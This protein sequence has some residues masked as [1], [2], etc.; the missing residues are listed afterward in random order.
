[1]PVP[2][3]EWPD[4]T[5][6][7][8]DI[9]RVDA[10]TR[11]LAGWSGLKSGR[12]RRR[13]GAGSY[14]SL[15]TSS[16]DISPA[17]RR[18]APGPFSTRALG[19]SRPYEHHGARSPSSSPPTRRTQRLH[20][21]LPSWTVPG[22]SAQNVDVRKL[23]SCTGCPSRCHEHRRWRKLAKPTG[24]TLASRTL[25]SSVPLI[26]GALARGAHTLPGRSA[27]MISRR[28]RHV[29]SLVAGREAP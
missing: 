7:G 10:G 16:I 19:K 13:R 23:S 8:L 21:K 9:N 11:H 29:F 4:A 15:R 6:A 22:R 20:S 1:M 5:A 27:G 25:C 12:Y 17:N 26:P 3:D 14:S 18:A 28:G 2:T 24:L